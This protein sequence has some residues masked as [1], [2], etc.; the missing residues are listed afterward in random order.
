M[1]QQTKNISGLVLLMSAATLCGMAGA[2]Q[3]GTTGTNTGRV[4]PPAPVSAGT[5]L[6]STPKPA[7]VNKSLAPS[8]VMQIKKQITGDFSYRFVTPTDESAPLLP[9]PAAAGN[10]NLIALTLPDART[11]KDA[12]LEIV[13][14]A[15]GKV[16]RLPIKAGTVTPL[17]ESAFTLVQTVLVPVQVKGR[18]VIGPVVTLTSADKK[19][20]KSWLLKASDNGV[21][22]FADVPLTEPVTVTVSAGGNAPLSQTQTLPQ[23][24]SSAGYQW[25]PI[26]VPWSDIKT[27]TP[28]PAPAIPAAAS[29]TAKSADG[30]T[31]GAREQQ[32]GGG[33]FLSTLV[34]IAVLGGIGYGLFWAYNNGKLK[35]FL[36]KIGVN[37]PPPGEMQTAGGPQGNPFEKPARAPIQPI[38]EGTADPLANGTGNTGYASSVPS[39]GP[40]LVATAGTYSG[41]IFPLSGNAADIGRDAGNAVPLPQDT[42]ASRRHATLQLNNGQFALLDNNSSNGTLVNGVRIPAQM[43]TPLR[44]GDEVQIGMTRFR[45]EA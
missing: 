40:R 35:T 41:Q 8:A 19:Y 22:Q 21:A 10:D 1:L 30:A 9:L 45:F 4:T 43:P 32:S 14:N 11:A 2:Q 34:S 38:T 13:D 20:T 16:A 3:A 44:P 5:S 37:L 25:Q 17:L 7:D 42:N 26:E 29:N 23:N 36:D 15:K 27:L 39:G 33:G 28:P 24:T 31:T 12:Q 18:G 6:P